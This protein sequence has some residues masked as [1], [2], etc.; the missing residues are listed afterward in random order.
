[1]VSQDIIF[2]LL[3]RNT[4]VDLKSGLDKVNQVQRLKKSSVV[5]EDESSELQHARVEER[6][7]RQQGAKHDNPQQENAKQ[8]ESA[9]TESTEQHEV[10]RSKPQSAHETTTEENVPETQIKG[11]NLDTYA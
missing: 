5:S 4:S 10:Q 6:Q 1:M 3:P 9:L 11:Q 7:R 2:P 8:D